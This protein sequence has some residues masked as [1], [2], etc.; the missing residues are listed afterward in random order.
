MTSVT[1]IL[2]TPTLRR[3]SVELVVQQRGVR[4]ALRTRW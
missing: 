1:T 2:Y 3:V 4:T